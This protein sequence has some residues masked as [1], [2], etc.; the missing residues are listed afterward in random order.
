MTQRLCISCKWHEIGSM[1]SQHLCANPIFLQSPSPVTGEQK[2]LYMG[3][4]ENL[5]QDIIACGP[6]GS[7]YE[8]APG[9]QITEDVKEIDREKA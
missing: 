5:R 9:V 3:L 7:M 2:L 6:Q 8:P 4:C 1:T